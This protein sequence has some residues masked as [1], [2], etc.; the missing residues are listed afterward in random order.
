MA[1]GRRERRHGMGRRERRHGMGRSF[2]SGELHG[3]SGDGF[4]PACSR[5]ATCISATISAPSSA[6]SSC[7]TAT[8]ASIASSTCTRS[9]CG[10]TRPSCRTPSARSP[11]RSS[12]AAS[13]REKHI[14]FN[15]SQVAEHAELAWVFNCVARARLAQPDDAVQ[16]EGRQGPRECLGRPLRLSDADGGRHSGLSRHP[17]AGRRGS[18]A[19]S[20]TVARHR[21]EIQQRFRPLDPRNTATAT[22]SFRCRSR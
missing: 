10:R 2:A 12:P 19:A 4:F 13:I 5:P 7:R 15:Q 8:T 20:R 9:R 11:R 6:S 3:I 16:G 22:L 1:W 18:E 14:V 17:R 21:A